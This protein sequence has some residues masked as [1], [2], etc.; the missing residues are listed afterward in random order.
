[1]LDVLS[2]AILFS[3]FLCLMSCVITLILLQSVS[4]SEL[5]TTPG[6]SPLFARTEINST[7]YCPQSGTGPLQT[8]LD[9][10]TLTGRRMHECWKQDSKFSQITMHRCVQTMK[11]HP[12]NYVYVWS[13]NFCE[14]F[15]GD[16]NSQ[17]SNVSQKLQYYGTIK[18]EWCGMDLSLDRAFV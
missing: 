8:N 10:V 15:K 13:F 9:P 17:I 11:I 1:M 18:Q 4:I 14:F 12:V 3:Y 16:W 6:C 2:S 5:H 7:S